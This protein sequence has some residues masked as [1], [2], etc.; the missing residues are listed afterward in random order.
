MFKGYTQLWFFVAA[1][2]SLTAAGSVRADNPSVTAVLD[3]SEA[4]VGETVQLQVRV[5]GG[6]NAEA[7]EEINV[8]GL[9]IRR[10]G[11]SQHFEMNNFNVTSSV[12]YSYTILPM[13]AGNFKIP[14]QTIKIAG[15]SLRTPELSLHVTDSSGSAAQPNPGG[16]N[17][18]QPSSPQTAAAGK[19]VFAELI[20]PKKS[21]YVGEVVP[22]QIQ[23]GFDPRSR[24]RLIDGPDIPAQGFTAQKLQ[25]S[26]E[27]METVN[28]RTYTVVAFKTAIAAA[29]A[30]KFEI[31][32]VKA[33]VQISM[34]RKSNSGSQSR[35]RSPFDLFNLDDPFSNPFFDDPFGQMSE[36][37]EVEVKS[38]ATSFEVKPLPPNA[39]P[40]FS[41]AIG[42]FTMATDAKP[43][44]LQVGDPIT[45]TSTITGR[46]NFD[47]VSAPVL[48]ND[49]G[50]HKYPPSS[51]FKQ[52]DDVGISGI[53]TFETVISPNEKKQTVPP[54]LFVYFDPAKENYVTL[55]SDAVPIAV[56]GGAPANLAASSPA[57]PSTVAKPPPVAPQA[58]AKPADIL[59]QLTERS[60]VAQS[61]IPLYRRPIFWGLQLIPLAGL[62]GFA[63]LKI[64]QAKI[65]NREAQRLASLNHEAS[66]LWRKL[67]RTETSPQEY[68]AEASRMV[69][70]KTALA[71]GGNRLNPN[72]VEPETVANIFRLDEQSKEMLR[73]LFERRDELRYSGA[74][75]GTERI[76]KEAKRQILD[77]VEGLRT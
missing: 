14:S 48:D 51:K 8:D 18:P 66:D 19:A 73:Y 58:E 42:N 27:R 38:E 50:W 40:Q 70:I 63:G 25:Q 69:Q 30:G 37:R 72:S 20:V 77:L 65:G 46:G 47:R 41:G 12:V 61:F 53:K 49:K 28:G 67:R 43:T 60:K 64:R 36:R 4:G 55:R 39:P 68:Y 9:E 35:Q 32:P 22:V 57:K 59:Y 75:N 44:N 16:R 3:S 24:P 7:P 29:R 62:F 1:L 45:V 34:P 15:Q 52:D 2:L 74:H 6:R 5:T 21:A 13:K 71:A 54:L 26:G 23:L 31:G 11:T 76:S 17:Q 33:R 10:T 56:E